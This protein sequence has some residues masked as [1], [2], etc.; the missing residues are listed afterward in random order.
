MLSFENPYNFTSK[1]LIVCSVRTHFHCI[2]RQ[3]DSDGECRVS[4][5]MYCLHNDNNN[6]NSE[7]RRKPTEPKGN[8]KQN[9]LK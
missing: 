8:T 6:F 2:A 1:T 5:G 7:Q 9:Y 3:N 4:I